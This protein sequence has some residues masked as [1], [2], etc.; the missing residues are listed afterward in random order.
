M[1]VLRSILRTRREDANEDE[2]TKR[3][4][5]IW[6]EVALRTAREIMSEKKT[7]LS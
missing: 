1:S 6:Y 2:S 4:G 7:A 3:K 5:T